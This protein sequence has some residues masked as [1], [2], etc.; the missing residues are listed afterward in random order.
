MIC[1]PIVRLHILFRKGE[2]VW[3]IWIVS[4]ALVTSEELLL[5][6]Q[7]IQEITG[8]KV[9]NW[10]ECNCPSNHKFTKSIGY[11]RCTSG[12][13][14]YG[15]FV[16]AHMNLEVQPILQHILSQKK[17]L[18]VINSC[19]MQKNSRL[20]CINVVK[21]KNPHFEIFYAK[22]ELSDAGFLMNYIEDAG[23]FGFRSTVSERELFQ[24]R[25]LGLVKAIRTV[26]EKAI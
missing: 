13:G 7:F 20:D 3:V 19:A 16:T 9:S 6:H 18:V 24:Q 5:R 11:Y 4:K 12:K 26:Y 17:A 1:Q 23:E 22:Q 10:I 2:Q 21:G 25:H 8:V 15:V 14:E